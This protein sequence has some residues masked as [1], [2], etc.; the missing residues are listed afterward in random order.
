M[1]YFEEW[2]ESLSPNQKLS[3]KFTDDLVLFEGAVHTGGPMREF[4]LYPL[5]RYCQ[6]NFFVGWSIQGFVL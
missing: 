1:A 3:V 4:L 2:L 6:A 5:K